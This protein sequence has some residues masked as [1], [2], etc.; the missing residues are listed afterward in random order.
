MIN[1]F[2]EKYKLQF[3]RYETRD[4]H[5]YRRT[6]SILNFQKLFHNNTIVELISNRL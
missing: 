5:L 6:I 2:F 3:K 4:E 1:A